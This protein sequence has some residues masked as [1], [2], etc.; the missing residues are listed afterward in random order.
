MEI[1]GSFES[2][3]MKVAFVMAVILTLIATFPR[4]PTTTR[5]HLHLESIFL[6]LILIYLR[7][8]LN[9]S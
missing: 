8:S 3:V 6:M 9:L 1:F 7:L 4:I 5:T 2:F